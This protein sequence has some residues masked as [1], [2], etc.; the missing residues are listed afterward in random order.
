MITRSDTRSDEYD[1]RLPQRVEIAGIDIPFWD[2]VR[3]IL[4]LALASIP[5]SIVI[6]VL[7]ALV[8]AVLSLVF[9]SF[10]VP[11]VHRPVS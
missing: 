7:Y 8:I 5:A 11:F 3:L 10:F 2:L 4:K 9:G 6:G 1:T